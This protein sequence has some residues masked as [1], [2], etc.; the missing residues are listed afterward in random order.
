MFTGM[1]R[2]CAHRGRPPLDRIKGSAVDKRSHAFMTS[3]ALTNE[4]AGAPRDYVIQ[5]PERLIWPS[6][7][8]FCPV[9]AFRSDG[10]PWLLELAI[11]G[12]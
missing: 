9:L 6:C 5:E 8:S 1:N 7:S 4:G 10:Q 3:R 11:S 12:P 2:R